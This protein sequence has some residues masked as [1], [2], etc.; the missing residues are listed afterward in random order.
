M[1]LGIIVDS[2]CALSQKEAEARGWGFLP[3]IAT[4]DGKD[5]LDGIDLTAEQ[6]YSM[7]RLEMQVKTATTPLGLVEKTIKQIAAKYDYVLIYPLSKH[8]SAQTQNLINNTAGMDNVFVVPSEAVGY[9]I[10]TDCEILL[11]LAKKGVSWE[12]IKEAANQLTSQQF[13]LAIPKTLTWLVRGGRV[14]PALASMAKLLKIVPIIA[15]EHGK[16]EKFGKSR[17]FDKTFEK[18][19]RIITKEYKNRSSFQFSIYHGNHPEIDRLK[20][21]A[22]KYL[23][24]S[25][26]KLFPP[27]I[28]NHIGPGVAGVLAHR[29]DIKD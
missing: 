7:I 19:S 23:T 6:Y 20:Q 25:H 12:K 13:G 5:Y 14:S 2:S 3:I 1:K 26:V 27:V 16:L 4:I 18:I 8:L 10:V 9:S 29:K 15:L 21:I 11:D 28:A 17:V 22:Q 24:I